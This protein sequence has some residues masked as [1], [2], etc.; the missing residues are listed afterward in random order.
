MVYMVFDEETQTK[1]YLKRKASRWHPDNYIV[2]HG[3]KIQGD[4]R[5]SWEYNEAHENQWIKIPENVTLLVGFNLKFDLLWQW[6]NPD[7]I[8]FFKRGGRIWDCQYVEYLLSG[9]DPRYHYCTLIV[10]GKL[11]IESNQ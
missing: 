6:D 10:T 11:Q 5:C 4:E 1:P 3:W 2:A 8:A 7:L 9:Q